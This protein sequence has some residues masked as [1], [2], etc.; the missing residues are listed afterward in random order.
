MDHP[1]IF[2]ATLGLSHPWQVV[3]VSFAKEER[4]LDIIVDYAHSNVAACPH[5][6]NARQYHGSETETWFHSDFFR[7]ATYL[8]ARIPNMEKCCCGSQHLVDRPWCRT[9]SKFTLVE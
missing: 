9:G 3:D 4:R 1:A 6:G 2:S 8:H 7:F 5:C